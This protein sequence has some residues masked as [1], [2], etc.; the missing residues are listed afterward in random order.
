MS[1]ACS[2]LGALN[3][4]EDAVALHAVDDA[5]D[6][7]ANDDLHGLLAARLGRDA[8]ALG[9]LEADA[10]VAHLGHAH[11]DPVAR[12]DGGRAVGAPQIERVE[13]RLP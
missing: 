1:P 10:L 12:V 6:L 7:L 5:G 9:E 13:E 4:Q 8:H 3:L 2:S 11:A